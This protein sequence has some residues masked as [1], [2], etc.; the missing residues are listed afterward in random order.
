MGSATLPPA[1]DSDLILTAS[2]T[3]TNINLNT[4]SERVTPPLA[5]TTPLRLDPLSE[6][7]EYVFG[8]WVGQPNNSFLKPVSV[9]TS[10]SISL[11]PYPRLQLTQSLSSGQCGQDQAT[12]SASLSLLPNI[13]TQ[14]S[15]TF[16]WSGPANQSLD[17]FS[18]NQTA[19]TLQLTS[20]RDN[21]GDYELTAC[22][23]IPG[24]TVSNR[25]NS[26]RYSISTDG[27]DQ[28]FPFSSC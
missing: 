9:N 25:C 8:V 10:F 17:P 11:Q 27:E 23:E 20:L 16:S 15:L 12:L 22:L 26:T 4:S 13:A 19:S 28:S 1:V 7:G 14:H 18:G 21:S 2:W 6:G 5:Q 24:T 3:H